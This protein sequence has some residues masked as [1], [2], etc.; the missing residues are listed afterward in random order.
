MTHHQLA[1]AS[2]PEEG[3]ANLDKYGYTVHED[4]LSRDEVAELRERLEEQAELERLEG[5]ASLSSSGHTGSDRYIGAPKPGAQLGWQEVKFL[6]NK[7]RV[8]IDLL[9][10]PVIHDYAGHLF[11]GESYNV[12]T[13]SGV[14]VRKGGSRQVMH[15]DQQAIP[16]PLDRP[17]MFVMMVCLSDF[18]AEMGATLVTPGSHQSPAPRLDSDPD[19]QAR[20]IGS[21][22]VPLE[23]KAGSALFWEGRTWHAAGASTSDRTRVSLGLGWAQHFVKP[24]E[25]YSAVLQ[26]NVYESLSEADKSLLGFDV[27]KESG[28]A[29]APRH[30]GDTRTNTN[31]RHP[32]VP[33]LRRQGTKHA[34]P[35]SVMGPVPLG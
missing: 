20:A 32:Y 24:Q 8:F 31:I 25:Y 30:P 19:Q 3:K 6:P 14:F 28:G 35:M 23:A 2:A 9:H 4:F 33:E 1:V 18:E 26:D 15:C 7:G 13:Y 27:Y 17:V 16:V 11:R 29:I 12:A 5:V 34:V 10:K 22:L 21:E